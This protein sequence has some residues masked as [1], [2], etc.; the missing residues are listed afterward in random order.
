MFA[1]N[2]QKSITGPQIH[3][4]RAAHS[5]DI[6]LTL[7]TISDGDPGSKL[8]SVFKEQ[9]QLIMTCFM[10]LGLIESSACLA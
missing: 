3:G 5:K 6:Y 7:S 10:A 4:L 2:K 9:T 8:T 1:K